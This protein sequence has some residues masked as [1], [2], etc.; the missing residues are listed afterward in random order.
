MSKPIIFSI[1]ADPHLSDRNVSE[2]E[3]AMKKSIDKTVE[4]G[5]SIMYIIGDIFT[6]RKSQSFNTL[7]AFGRVLDYAEEKGI[8]I[9]LFPGNHD[10]I[11]YLS[12]RSYLDIYRHYPA[13]RLST[14][15]QLFGEYGGWHIFLLP[16]FREVDALLPYIEKI[17]NTD[18]PDRSVLLTHVA[19]DGVRNNDGSVVKGILP[20][21]TFQRFKQVFVGH[22]HDKQEIKNVTYIGSLLQNNFGEDDLKGITYFHSD[23]SITQESVAESR[24]LTVEID[25]QD[26]GK[27]EIENLIEIYEETPDRIRF[28]FL[29]TKQQFKSVPRSKI[30]GKGIKVAFKENIIEEVTVDQ[31]VADNFAAFTKGEILT[32]WDDYCNKDEE[33]KSVHQDGKDIL[34]KTL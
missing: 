3:L 15:F 9:P 32:E 27:Q 21:A 23:G 7:Q 17:N 6:D 28:K 4:R 16:F 8:T 31:E 26:K 10:K 18:I 11:D 24:Y 5:C 30:E 14:D 33:R 29:G 13:V 20:R 19:I 22:Y 2:V 1:I 12:E 34:E 25:L